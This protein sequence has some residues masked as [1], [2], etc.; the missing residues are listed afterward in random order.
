[1]N[2]LESWIERYVAVWNEPDAAQRRRAIGALWASDG[3]T[4]HRL[5]ESRGLAAIED[6][7]TSAYDKWVQGSGYEFRPT[8]QIVGHHEFMMFNWEMGPKTSDAVVSL[9]LNF[10]QLDAQDRI[11]VDLQF[12]DSPPAPSAEFADLAQRYVATWNEA[13]VGARRERVESLWHP[14]GAHADARDVWRGHREIAERADAMF[15]ARGRTG[16]RLRSTARIDGHHGAV[17][18]DWE[19]MAIDGSRVEAQGTNLLLLGDDGRLLH[20]FWFDRVERAPR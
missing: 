3:M 15:A 11:L 6:R 20:D 18:L 13:D 2:K 19:L 17:R 10:A 1:M 7:V 8:P 5:L 9:G 4:C 16:R 12:P 14:N